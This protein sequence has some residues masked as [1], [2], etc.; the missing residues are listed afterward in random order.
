MSLVQAS[1][2]WIKQEAGITPTMPDPE[3]EIELINDETY[4]T[5]AGGSLTGL[6]KGIDTYYLFPEMLRDL[7]TV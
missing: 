5:E 3:I 6:L 7:E 1:R 2:F 4:E